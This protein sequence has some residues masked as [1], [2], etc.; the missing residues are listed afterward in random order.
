MTLSRDSLREQNAGGCARSRGLSPCPSTIFNRLRNLDKQISKIDKLIQL[1]HWSATPS[2]VKYLINKRIKLDLK[3]KEVRN[4]RKYW[5]MTQYQKSL[6]I[7]KRIKLDLKRNQQ[8][9]L[10]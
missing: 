3:R 8:K 6:L 10:V 7:D 5:G 2:E 9:R 4:K 1:Q